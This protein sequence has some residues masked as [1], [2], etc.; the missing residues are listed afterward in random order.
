MDTKEM[1]EAYGTWLTEDEL[2]EMFTKWIDSY[3]GERV[4]LIE[5]INYAGFGLSALTLSLKPSELHRRL[6]GEEGWI[7]HRHEF[8]KGD[9]ELIAFD[10]DPDCARWYRQDQLP[11]LQ[12]E[13]QE[14]ER[15]YLSDEYDYRTS[16]GAPN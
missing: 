13:H 1:F 8:L 6:W 10:D 3:Y 7:D 14:L 15:R 9:A 5:P 4:K 11:E 2:D 12:K 16:Q